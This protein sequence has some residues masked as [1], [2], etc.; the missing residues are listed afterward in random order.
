[1]FLLILGPHSWLGSLWIDTDPTTAHP[2]FKL[3][4]QILKVLP[5]P[6][7]SN[8]LEAAPLSGLTAAPSSIPTAAPCSDPTAVDKNK[9]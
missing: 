7:P 3:H 8:G 4:P 2:Q 6:D 5:E 9:N 1:M